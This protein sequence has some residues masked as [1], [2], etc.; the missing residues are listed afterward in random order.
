MH[1]RRIG[2][3]LAQTAKKKTFMANN[4]HALN[5]PP[6]FAGLVFSN[7]YARLPP[8]FYS[9]VNPTPV[10]QPGLIKVNHDLAHALNLDPAALESPEGVAMLA[11]NLLPPGAEPLAQAYA[12][13]QFGYFN[14]QL[15][16]G[17][18]ILL[19]EVEDR[20]GGLK[21]LQ[22]KGAG[23]T[24]YSRRGDGRAGIGPVV[25]EYLVSEAMHALGIKTTRALAAVTTG[26]TI[27]RDEAVPGAVLTRV[28]SSH[29]RIGTFE[30]FRGKG[31]LQSIIRLAD[32]VI[33]RHYPDA[34]AAENPYLALLDGVMNAQASLVSS[35]MHAGFIHG[36]MNT[37]NMSISGETI[38]YGP[39]AFMDVYNPDTVF[40]S[41]DRDGRYA[42]GSQGSIALWNL[43]RLAECL[44]P[45][46]AEDTASAVKIA[47]QQ[48]GTFALVFKSQWLTGMRRKIGLSLEL[49][50]DEVL[51]EAL[52]QM[53]YEQQV[54]YTQTFRYL[55]RYLSDEA[56]PDD[57][58]PFTE[59]FAADPQPLRDWLARWH[60]RLQKEELPA[61]ETARAMRQINPVY[62]PRNHRIEAAIAAAQNNADY[63]LVHEMAEVLSQPYT[64][65]AGFEHYAEPAEPSD[66]PY[67]TFCGT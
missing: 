4:P 20:Q 23:P 43:S 33:E 30:Y 64:E 48:L 19:G 54:D 39:C 7:H 5:L 2:A 59:L 29:V 9:R 36:V 61:E 41:I 15:G 12:G 27:F 56:T 26:E 32:F 1:E 37:D 55:T 67:R 46:F 22:L 40:S 28:A 45:L 58:H 3:P 50:E 8:N 65:R 63:T 18:A 34:R 6:E 49:P 25:R 57:Q 14:P 62:I 24:P 10:R 11:G 35:W 42:F 66:R 17:R 53:M 51:I 47:E 60:P 31:D 52:L 13:H 44:L 16:D 38:D 21:D